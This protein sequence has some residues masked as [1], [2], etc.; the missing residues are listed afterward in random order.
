MPSRGVDRKGA[1]D[2]S[3]RFRPTPG[4]VNHGENLDDVIIQTVRDDI[5]LDGIAPRF[6]ALCEN[7]ASSSMHKVFHFDCPR[8]QYHC[9]ASVIWCFD[10]RFELAFQKFLKRLGILRADPVRIAGG[11][12]SLASP[13]R[14]FERE[15]VLEQ[16]GASM[17]LHGT[18]RVVLAM[19]SDC[20]AYGGLAAF[21]GNTET[22]AAHHANELRRATDV[23]RLRFRCVSI[24]GYFIDFEGV[25]RVDGDG[26]GQT[27]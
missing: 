3:K 27:A 14:D 23:L 15:F 9:D 1:H 20:G 21:G 17:R 5:R 16:V 2:R 12:K 19:H 6:P 26:R 4:G 18:D 25:W 13:A 10:S 22:E 11:P 24:E 7:G 8:E